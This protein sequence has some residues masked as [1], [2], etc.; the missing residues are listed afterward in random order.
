MMRAAIL[1]SLFLLSAPLIANALDSCVVPTGQTYTI[2]E[3]SACRRV[4]NSHASG[5]AIMVPTKTA[6]E[7]STGGNAF[8]NAAPAGVGLAA[9]SAGPAGWNAVANLPT[10]IYGARAAKLGD[11]RVLV[12]GGQAINTIL[13]TC[14]IY[15]PSTNIWSAA[16]NLPTARSDAISEPL[17]DGRVLSCTGLNSGGGSYSNRCDIY[18]GSLNTWTQVASLTNSVKGAASSVLLDGRPIV[19]GGSMWSSASLR[20][21]AYNYTTNTWSSIATLQEPRAN[22]SMATL[23]NGRVMICGGSGWAPNLQ[24]C[25]TLDPANGTWASVASLPQ[26]VTGAQ[27]SEILLDGTILNCAGINGSDFDGIPPTDDC[28]SYNQSLNT[29]T[30]VADIPT[31]RFAAASTTLNDGRFLVCGGHDGPFA[32]PGA[33]YNTCYVYST[34]SVGASCSP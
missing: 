12:C 13:N 22:S 17:S 18:N 20:C 24:T 6:A 32:W 33:S 16:A 15:N 19:C 11:G 28:H 21:D 29:W 26:V 4:T 7:W 3:H 30:Q 34:G 27:M 9:C 10:A 31:A 8:I 2:N 1:F 23:T 5:S 14:H 25:K